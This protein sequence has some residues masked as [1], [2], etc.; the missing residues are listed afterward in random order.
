M[1]FYSFLLSGVSAIIATVA[2]YRSHIANQIALESNK[3]AKHYN[4]RPMR[5]DACNLIKDFA[6]YCSRF[7]TMFVQGMVSGTRELM[8]QRDSFRK[9]FESL[10]PLGMTDLEEKALELSRGAVRLQRAL[11]RTRASDPK[12]LESQYETLEDNIYA[13]TD[14]FAEEKNALPSLFAKYL[15]DAA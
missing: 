1:E 3:I 7:N 13:I 2:L 10:G 11:D 8:E 4:L 5:L 14:W 9:E 6:D 12:P 15:G